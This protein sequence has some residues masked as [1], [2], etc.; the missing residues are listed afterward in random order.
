MKKTILVLTVAILLPLSAFAGKKKDSSQP[1]DTTDWLNAPTPDGSPTLKET[2]D[3]LEK[4]LRTFAG[5]GTTRD[6]SPVYWNGYSYP[7]YEHAAIDN[8]CNFHIVTVALGDRGRREKKGT[9]I[10]VPLGAVKSVET[11]SPSY[12]DTGERWETDVVVRT[13]APVIRANGDRSEWSINFN[14]PMPNPNDA[15]AIEVFPKDIAPRVKSAL[16]HA[17]ALCQGTFKAPAQSK[18]PF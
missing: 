5:A 13:T 4:T 7:V 1:Q 16:D 9:E 8:Q 12:D 18:D 3:W 2:S 11:N 14:K 15:S 6:G 17:A 10:L